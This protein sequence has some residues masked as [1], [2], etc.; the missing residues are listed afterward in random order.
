MN[1]KEIVHTIL[2]AD[3][4]S[5]DDDN[6]LYAAVLAE[7]NVSVY[8]LTVF[9]LL[10]DVRDKKLPSLDTISRLRRLTQMNYPNLRGNE[11]NERHGIKVEKALTDLG[12][13]TATHQHI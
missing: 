5:R 1:Y 13:S 10:R 8:S 9:E 4:D 6:R 3:E 7:L 12:Y 11:Y 2:S